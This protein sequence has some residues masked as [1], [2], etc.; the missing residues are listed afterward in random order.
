[1]KVKDVI[2]KACDFIGEDEL[3]VAMQKA[4]NI[5]SEQNELKE[6]LL[7]CFNLVREEIACEYQPIMQVE[8]F[9]IKNFPIRDLKFI[10]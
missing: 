4:E 2:I 9:T 3:A 7:K 5:T 8:K 1:M 6:K 10:Q